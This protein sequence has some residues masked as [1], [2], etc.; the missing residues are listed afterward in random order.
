MDNNKVWSNW[1][2]NQLINFGS[3][4]VN[5]ELITNGSNNMNLEF[6]QINSTDI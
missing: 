3:K 1:V 4:N 6:N 2:L 5:I